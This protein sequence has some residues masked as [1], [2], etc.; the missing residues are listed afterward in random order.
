MKKFNF[1]PVDIM[2]LP[3]SPFESQNRKTKGYGQITRMGGGVVEERKNEMV[4]I[5][6]SLGQSSFSHTGK[7]TYKFLDFGQ[8]SMCAR[9]S[10]FQNSY[11]TSFSNLSTQISER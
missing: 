11:Q 7:A 5:N 8:N 1:L 4:K 2:I 3:S 10:N 6:K 9:G